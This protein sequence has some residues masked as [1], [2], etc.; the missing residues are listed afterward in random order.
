[1]DKLHHV[2]VLIDA[3]AMT[4]LK[5]EDVPDVKLSLREEQCLMWAA[6]GKTYEEIG[7]L[8]NLSFY[9]VRSHLD[10]ARLKLHAANLTHAVAMALALGVIRPVALRG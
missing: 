1:M 4:G 5:F 7:E 10:L 3:A 2:S 8:T 6:R 9:S